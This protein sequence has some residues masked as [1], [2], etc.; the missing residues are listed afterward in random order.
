MCELLVGLPEVTVLRIDG[1]SGRV[2]GDRA[3]GEIRPQCERDR[4]R[5]GL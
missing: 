4:H 1:V 5:S 2:L 3:G